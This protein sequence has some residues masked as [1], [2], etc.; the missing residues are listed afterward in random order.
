[1]SGLNYVRFSLLY[2]LNPFTTI[3]LF[4][5]LDGIEQR[6]HDTEREFDSARKEAKTAKDRFNSVKQKRFLLFLTR[7]EY[8]NSFHRYN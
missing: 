6:L 8:M 2:K 5:R 3:Y 4:Y 7:I 1:M